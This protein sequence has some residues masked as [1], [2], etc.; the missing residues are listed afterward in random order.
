[1]MNLL[2]NAVKFTPSG[3]H[4]ELRLV[5]ED[6]AAR[7]DVVDSG[8]GIAPSFLP[9]VFDMYGQSVSVTTR[10][11]GGLGIGLALVR[12]IVALH[13]GRV[14]AFSEGIGKGARFSVW[15][16]L[17]DSDPTPLHGGAGDGDE[18]MAG[19]RILVVDDMEEM[20]LVFKS[21]LELGGATVFEATRARQAL[22]IL[23]REKIDLLISDIS[24]PEM[25]GY[26]LLRRVKA[27]PK[28]A[29]L[30]AIAVTGMQREH[31][32]VQARAAGFSAQLGKPVSIDRLNAIVREL[33]PRRT[34]LQES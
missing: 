6:D 25:D 18:G 13:G 21:L 3:G 19:L 17:L 27:N 12:E 14:E 5:R 23:E 32:I 33:L 30:P 28:W 22:E 10:S 4:I 20:L 26:E 11:K 24:M 34:A 29:A 8:Q 15:L 16:P 2:S 31:D 9:H 7:I 1:V